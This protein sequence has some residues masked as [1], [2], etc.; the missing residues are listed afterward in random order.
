MNYDRTYVT[1]SGNGSG[2]AAR[3]AN[4]TPHRVA[5]GMSYYYRRF[6]GSFNFVW[7]ADRPESNTYG[8]YYSQI[9]KFDL[10]L[11]WK[12]H[13]YATLYVTG[14]NISN[15]PDIWYQ[16]PPGSPEGKNGYLRAMESYGANWVFGVR[17]TF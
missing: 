5:G 15:Q 9:T 8:R 3:R 4:L 12:L 17:G 16:S 11:N 2:A 13:N 10:T 1:Q 7:G 14:R 6:N